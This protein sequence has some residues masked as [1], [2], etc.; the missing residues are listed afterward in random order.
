MNYPPGLNY[1]PEF[2]EQVEQSLTP[3]RLAQVS[4]SLTAANTA[5]LIV[6]MQPNFCTNDETKNLVQA[7]NAILPEI[8]DLTVYHVH[9]AWGYRPAR[10]DIQFATDVPLEARAF[11]KEANSAFRAINTMTSLEKELKESGIE[12]V[13]LAGVNLSACIRDTAIDSCKA[14]FNTIVLADLVGNNQKNE[15][16]KKIEAFEDMAEAGTTYASTAAVLKT[17]KNKL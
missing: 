5:I 13:V 12:N 15:H 8:N 16:L 7:I 17:I 1:N 14:A 2:R 6:D 9:T 4:Q 11:R 10:Q 3:D